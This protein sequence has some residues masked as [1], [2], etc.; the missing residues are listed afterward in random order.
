VWTIG[1]EALQKV[2]IDEMQK[3]MSLTGAH[4]G[5]VVI[6]KDWD[7]FGKSNIVPNKP[8][9]NSAHAKKLFQRNPT[10]SSAIPQLLYIDIVNAEK[11]FLRKGQAKKDRLHLWQILEALLPYF[12]GL[13]LK[14]G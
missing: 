13:R 3:A 11:F 4:G 1:D 5:N 8:S 7:L 10:D 2:A 9:F 12:Q 14:E 6:F